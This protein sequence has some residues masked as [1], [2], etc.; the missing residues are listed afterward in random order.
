MKLHKIHN[1]D[2]CLFKSQSIIYQLK[3]YQLTVIHKNSSVTNI[4]ANSY[5]QEV[6]SYNISANSYLQENWI[7]AGSDMLAVKLNLNW[8]QVS[9]FTPR[10]IIQHCYWSKTLGHMQQRPIKDTQT[11]SDKPPLPDRVS[12]RFREN[13]ITPYFRNHMM[14][15][16][17]TLTQLHL[18][19]CL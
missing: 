17:D 16:T 19:E 3:M 5:P 1:T 2:L 18:C 11:T 7:L 10:C 8:H 14:R 9:F 4:S 6:I 13:C 12:V 15:G